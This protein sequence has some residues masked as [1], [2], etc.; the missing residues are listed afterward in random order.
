MNS[1]LKRKKTR[2]VCKA[3]K[4]TALF[5][6]V[7]GLILFFSGGI[8]LIFSSNPYIAVW[9]AL[10]FLGLALFLTA[11]IIPSSLKKFE[12]GFVQVAH[13]IGKVIFGAIL[14]LI[15]Y[16]LL[17]PV[18]LILRWVKGLQPFY[19]WQGAQIPD[20][21][22]AWQKKITVVDHRLA[23]TSA[24]RLPVLL[25]IFA[26]ISYFIK[27]GHYIYLPILL[28]LLILGLLLFFLK[29]SSLAPFI[30]TIF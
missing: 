28:I 25:Q 8:K 24:K 13:C 19:R 12:S 3:L 4:G 26:V 14:T 18:G 16:F 21:T 20:I 9:Q 22:S 10:F 23:S 15:F 30:Y 2:E 5:G 1:F 29:S 6:M 17:C 11:L 27:H 7:C